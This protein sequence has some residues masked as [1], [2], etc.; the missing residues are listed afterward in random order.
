MEITIGEVQNQERYYLYSFA[1]STGI[2]FYRNGDEV[3]QFDLLIDDDNI[4][5]ETELA[6]RNFEFDQ[7]EAGL[8]FDDL[9]S[10]KK[11]TKVEYL[12]DKKNTYYACLFTWKLNSKFRLKTLS[13]LNDAQFSEVKLSERAIVEL[14]ESANT[15]LVRLTLKVA[16]QL[17]LKYVEKCLQTELKDITQLSLRKTLFP[18]FIETAANYF[19]QLVS[20]LKR[21]VRRLYAF[22][23][24]KFGLRVPFKKIG[25]PLRKEESWETVANALFQLDISNLDS[26]Q[27]HK[28]ATI[29]N[30]VLV[31]PN[32]DLQQ[33]GERILTKVDWWR[34]KIGRRWLGRSPTI[35]IRAYS[36]EREKLA[37]ITESTLPTVL[38]WS[39]RSAFGRSASKLL[40]SIDFVL[41]SPAETEI[42]SNLDQC[43]FF[44]SYYANP[45]LAGEKLRGDLF[46]LFSRDIGPRFFDWFAEL[47]E[48]YEMKHGS[49]KEELTFLREWYCTINILSL[50]ILL[51]PVGQRP[52]WSELNFYNLHP[53]RYWRDSAIG[54]QLGLPDPLVILLS[55]LL[56]WAIQT[57]DKEM[58]NNIAETV[59]ALEIDPTELK[60]FIRL[61]L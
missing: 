15:R 12:R 13:L 20:L 49:R 6:S 1:P 50:E 11:L 59:R 34:L 54:K 2:G 55:N 7:V 9:D 29:L 33:E 21:K 43:A 56:S 40:F 26:R 58:F 19:D 38:D 10:L 36:M 46:Y 4:L 52:F 27:L 3:F 24:L 41:S 5:H 30:Q 48:L 37:P 53:P 28:W 32:R 45:A 42:W 31:A 44:I 23:E 8:F 14:R 60:P 47:P 18:S 25:Q 39:N 16:S 22:E 57:N 17:K 61:I 35:D 51:H